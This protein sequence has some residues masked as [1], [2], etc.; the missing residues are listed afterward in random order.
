MIITRT[1]RQTLS[2]LIE[3]GALDSQ[4]IASLMWPTQTCSHDQ[5]VQAMDKVLRSMQMRRLVDRT[6]SPGD[7]FQASPLG[8]LAMRATGLMPARR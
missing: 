8:C 2:L 1:E 4:A 6:R 5:L 7:A 3:A